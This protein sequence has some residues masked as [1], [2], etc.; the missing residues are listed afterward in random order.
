[1]RIGVV[2][3]DCSLPPNTFFGSYFAKTLSFKKW[4]TR[5]PYY[6]DILS[7]D[8]ICCHMRTAEEVDVELQYAIEAKIDYFAYVWHTD[9]KTAKPDPNI[10]TSVTWPHAWTQDYARKLH[11][12]SELNKKIKLCA[13]LLCGHPYTESDY[14]SLAKEMKEE[15]YEKVDGRPVVYL[16]GGYRTD[17]IEILRQFPNQYNTAD[18]YVVFMNNGVESSDGDYSKADAVS[19]YC[20][21]NKGKNIA[22]YAELLDRQ[23]AYNEDRKKYGVNI[24]PSFT[25]GWNPI[26]RIET[27]VPWVS[28]SQ[29]VYSERATAAELEEGAKKLA[30]WICQ[31][32][33]HVK[34]DHILTFAWNE[35]EEG[36]YICPTYNEDGS[37]NLECIHAFAQAV[38]IFRSELEQA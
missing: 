12:K 13:I 7:E 2:N 17:V 26:P 5:V 35:F 37:I 6:A 10:K 30:D 1:M 28:Y 23:I 32:R 9:D 31:N 27:V 25:V 38:K 34:I 19:A 11:Q 14:A 8:N 21:S 4:R 20:C 18:P 36:G 22:T 33:D 29:R 24:V 3:W 16:F 15:Y